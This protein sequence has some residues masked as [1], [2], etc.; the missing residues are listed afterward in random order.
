M[1]LDNEIKMLKKWLDNN[2]D[3]PFFS[4]LKLKKLGVYICW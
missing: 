2:T 4:D 3:L 1:K